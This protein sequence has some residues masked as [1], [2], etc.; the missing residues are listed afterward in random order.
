MSQL[1]YAE[2]EN[3]L[4]A[5]EAKARQTF[6]DNFQP[7]KACH[8]TLNL[9]SIEYK[10]TRAGKARW[11]GQVEYWQVHKPLSITLWKEDIDFLSGVSGFI[12]GTEPIAFGVPV[13]VITTHSHPKHGLNR[14]DNV[15]SSQVNE[16]IAKSDVDTQEAPKSEPISPALAVPKA[17]PK[18]RQGYLHLRDLL[19]KNGVVALAS[20]DALEAHMKRLVMFGYATKSHRKENIWEAT[21]KAKPK[22]IKFTEVYLYNLA[23]K[24]FAATRYWV[25][26]IDKR[27]SGVWYG[28]RPSYLWNKY[29]YRFQQPFGILW[30]K[31]SSLEEV[32]DKS[33]PKISLEAVA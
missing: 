3:K 9:V 26:G 16:F 14:L 18:Q 32:K 20:G 25:D 30:R 10:P 5:Q 8:E 4:A 6:R 24:G 27:D 17:K 19:R 22:F 11:I 21:E 2:C 12:I 7:Y 1:S 28:I 13:Q 29:D 23:H 15:W 33:A 31:S